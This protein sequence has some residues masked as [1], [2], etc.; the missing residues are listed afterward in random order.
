MPTVLRFGPFRFFFYSNEANE[1]AHIHVQHD[2]RAAKFWL[3][4]I[5]LA[6]HSGFPAR[7]LRTLERLA[8][9]HQAEFLEA[10]HEFFGCA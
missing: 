6:A 4:P 2:R 1:P 10:W 3:K 9:K 8:R 7:E 5:G